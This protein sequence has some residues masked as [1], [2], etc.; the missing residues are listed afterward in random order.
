MNTVEVKVQKS[1]GVQLAEKMLESQ[2]Q[3][4]RE[5]IQEYQNPDSPIRKMFEE[6]RKENKNS[7]TPIR[8]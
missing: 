2:R 7:G 1:T 5:A 6:L 8:S 3:T 4:A